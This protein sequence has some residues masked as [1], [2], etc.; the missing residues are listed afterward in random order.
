MRSSGKGWEWNICLVVL[1]LLAF[2]PVD[3]YAQ[4]GYGVLKVTSFP[5]GARAGRASNAMG[6]VLHGVL[7]TNADATCFGKEG[8]V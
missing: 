2:L 7:P 4:S 6:S 5:S 8:V 3:L 1:V